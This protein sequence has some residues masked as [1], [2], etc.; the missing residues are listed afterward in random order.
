MN[1][2]RHVLETK[3][4]FLTADPAATA[5]ALKATPDFAP[6]TFTPGDMVTQVVF[7]IDPQDG[8]PLTAYV[9]PLPGIPAKVAYMLPPP[10]RVDNEGPTCGPVDMVITAMDPQGIPR[11]YAASSA[12]FAPWREGDTLAPAVRTYLEEFQAKLKSCPGI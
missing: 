2:N 5:A 4:K 11:N 9:F 8:E 3:S 10:Y 1:P 6:N 7:A 12:F